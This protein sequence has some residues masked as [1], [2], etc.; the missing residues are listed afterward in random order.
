MPTEEEM[1]AEIEQLR[2]ENEALKKPR[3]GKCP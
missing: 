1:Q 2:A 3:V